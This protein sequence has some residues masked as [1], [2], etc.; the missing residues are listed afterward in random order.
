LD[1]ASEG[2]G[3]YGRIESDQVVG[4]LRALAS[5][6]LLDQFRAAYTTTQLE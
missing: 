6:S 5:I 1:S 3:S 2:C 4:C